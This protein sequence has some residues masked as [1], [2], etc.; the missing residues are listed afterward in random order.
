MGS[1]WRTRS[2]QPVR[3]LPYLLAALASDLG[4][5][6]RPFLRPD[7]LHQVAQQVV[8]LQVQAWRARRVRPH[9]TIF[10]SACVRGMLTCVQEKCPIAPQPHAISLSPLDSNPAQ[11]ASC[12]RLPPLERGGASRVFLQCSHTRHPAASALAFEASSPRERELP[13]VWIVKPSS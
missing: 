1:K 9:T 8:L 2:R 10:S 13:S 4:R 11:S 3:T 5:D 7:R 6:D 12:P